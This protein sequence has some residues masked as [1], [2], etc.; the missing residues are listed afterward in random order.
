MPV[1]S[2]VTTPAAHDV[3]G[4]KKINISENG[5]PYVYIEGI[6]WGG[7]GNGVHRVDVSVDGG[8]HFTRAEILEKPVKQRYKGNWGCTCLPQTLHHTMPLHTRTLT[9]LNFAGVFFE[10]K[11][12]L[13]KEM[14]AQVLRGEKVRLDVCSKA[15]NSAWNMQPETPQANYNPHG[16]CVNHWYRV[17]VD[18]DGALDKDVPYVP[19]EKNGEFGQKPSGGKFTKPF[20]NQDQPEAAKKKGNAKE[21]VW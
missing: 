6:A 1:Q 9:L 5:V 4:A 14:A 21:C 8:K 11:V 13:P 10:K 3:L 17:P 18:M 7:G 2:F 20:D 12:E 19:D 16:C 15:L